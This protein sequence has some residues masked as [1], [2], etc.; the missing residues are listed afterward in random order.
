MALVSHATVVVEANERSGTVSQAWEAIRLGRPL[1]LLRSLVEDSS[2]Q[3]PRLLLEYGAEVLDRVDPLI[4]ELP[5]V[6]DVE[7][8]EAPF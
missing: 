7:F 8:A 2:L 4:A 5:S 3:W 6:R 1:F